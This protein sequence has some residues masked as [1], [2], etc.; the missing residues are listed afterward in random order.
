MLMLIRVPARLL[1]LRLVMPMVMATVILVTQIFFCGETPLFTIPV[2]GFTL[3]GYEEGFARGLIIMCRVLG[4]VSLIL[5]LS[6]STPADKLFIAAAWFKIPKT[7]IEIALLVYRYIFVIAE[8]FITMNNAQRIRLGYHSW[9]QSVKS[10]SMLGACLILRAYDR[11]E[12]VFE[13]MLVR[14]YTNA[15]LNYRQTFS[16]KDGIVALCLGLILAGFYL[17]GR[18]I[19]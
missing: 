15:K 12:R 11:A 4:G 8:E 19:T 7:F 14:G 2:W 1:L 16:W 13:A 6:I 3:V 10:L 18:I 5:L 17:I 9:R